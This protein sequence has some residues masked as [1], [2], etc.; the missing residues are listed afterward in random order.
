M[1]QIVNTLIV[2]EHTSPASL[3]MPTFG[4]AGAAW[5]ANTMNALAR[6]STA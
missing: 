3:G 2:T 4:G 6:R 5:D 1:Y